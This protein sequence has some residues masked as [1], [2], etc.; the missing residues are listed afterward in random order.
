VASST[1]T[2]LTGDAALRR[3]S[4]ARRGRFFSGLS[5]AILITVFWGFAPS[6]YLKELFGTPPLRPI[7][8]AHGLLFTT[9][10]VLLVVQTS[11]VRASRVDV[12]RRLG[13]AGAT[14]AAAMVIVGS[15]ADMTG[16][17]SRWDQWL[18][19]Q[20]T[21]FENVLRYFAGN[22]GALAQF[23]VLVGAAVLL[24]RNVQAHKRLMMLATF[25]LLPAAL[26][27]MIDGT[28]AMIGTKAL[29]DAISAIAPLGL[30]S[31]LPLPYYLALLVYDWR[32]LGRV[33]AATLWGGVFLLAFLPLSVWALL[34]TGAMQRLAAA[35]H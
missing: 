30:M 26:A 19:A 6:Y 25:A 34:Q 23:A 33:H 17:N 32:A 24:R 13:I 1:A 20:P 27:R 10:V 5:I 15:V 21:V 22:T 16:P 28:G 35:G 8:H 18:A 14:L 2:V 11:L 31:W 12:H 7:V 29:H 3:A 4:T 9:W